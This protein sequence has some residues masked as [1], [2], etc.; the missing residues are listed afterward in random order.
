M[1]HMRLLLIAALTAEEACKVAACVLK[2]VRLHR[3]LP[4]YLAAQGEWD[5][6][7]QAAEQCVCYFSHCVP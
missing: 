4:P 7:D 3:G 1:Y 2:G 5:A 6:S